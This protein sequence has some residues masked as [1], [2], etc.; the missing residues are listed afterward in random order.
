MSQ[1]WI[2]TE[3]VDATRD[4]RIDSSKPEP[5]NFEDDEVGVLYRALRSNLGRCIGKVYIDTQKK[6]V[7][8]IGW[9]FQKR[10]EY[11]RSNRTYLLET[12]VTILNGPQE[13][14]RINHRRK[15]Y[16]YPSVDNQNG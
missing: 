16:A 14:F 2:Q 3:S 4:I 1:L 11:D 6:E 5:T 8:P 12:W 13:R 9:V 15:H 10:Q 7:V